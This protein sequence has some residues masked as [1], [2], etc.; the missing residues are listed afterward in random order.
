GHTVEDEIGL[1]ASKH[2]DP[3]RQADA[4]YRLLCQLVGWLATELSPR[5]RV[6]SIPASLRAFI[7]DPELEDLPRVDDV[8]QLAS[9]ILSL[10]PSVTQP[11][12]R[13]RPDE[14]L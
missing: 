2:D 6:A 9:K 8:V 3:P 7:E 14:M 13:V 11:F 1:I 10:E 4:F 12:W 5:I